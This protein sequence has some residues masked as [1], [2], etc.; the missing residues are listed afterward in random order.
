MAKHDQR[1]KRFVQEFLRE[2]VAWRW[3]SW[4]A[5]IDWKRVVWLQQE[6][7]ADLAAGE[8]HV[9]DLVAH[10]HVTTAATGVAGTPGSAGF[11]LHLELEGRDAIGVFTV[12]M[13]RYH[14]RLRTK[15]APTPVLSLAVLRHLQLDGVGHIETIQTVFNNWTHRSRFDYFAL[16]GLHGSDHV[17]SANVVAVAWSALM[18]WPDDQR[19]AMALRA[20]ERIVSSAETTRRKILLIE[21]IQAYAPLADDQRIALESLIAQNPSPEV[22]TMKTWFETKYDEGYEKGEENGLEKGIEKGMEKGTETTYR[23]VLRQ[24]LESR[25]GPLSATLSQRLEKTTLVDLQSL[26][27]QACSAK[28][29]AELG[30]M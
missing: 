1:F 22:Q 4:E 24:L 19:V 9:I 20:I 29:L 8:A 11:W 21:F 27:Q 3:P 17:E 30:L 14:E 10:L 23:V 5:L 25:F 18:R 7:V 12:R 13:A 26:F 16:P 28:S 15:A 6:L 2:L